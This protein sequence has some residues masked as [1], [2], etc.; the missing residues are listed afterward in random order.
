MGEFGGFLDKFNGFGG[1]TA[2]WWVT[3]NMLTWWISLKTD[4]V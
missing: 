4:F 1:L 2:K 3:H